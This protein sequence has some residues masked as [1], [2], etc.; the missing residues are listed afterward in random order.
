MANR[1]TSLYGTRR[2]SRERMVVAPA[3]RVAAID[4]LFENLAAAPE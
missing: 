3:L 4:A 2:L 1:S